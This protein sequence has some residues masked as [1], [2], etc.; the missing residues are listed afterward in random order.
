MTC[1]VGHRCSSDPMLLWLWYRSA[2]VALIWPQDW[3]LPHATG[4]GLKKQTNKQTKFYPPRLSF[5]FDGELK[6]DKLKQEN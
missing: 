6:N 5:R 1:G 2:A 4:A 3:E